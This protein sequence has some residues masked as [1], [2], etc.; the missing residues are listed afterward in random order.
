ME[1]YIDLADLKLDEVE[2]RDGVYIGDGE[3][4]FISNE[5][6]DKIL[7][8]ITGK[9]EIVVWEDENG[10]PFLKLERVE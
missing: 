2:M 9:R 8:H 1:G 3:K 10:F 6:I 7:H 5:T 4:L